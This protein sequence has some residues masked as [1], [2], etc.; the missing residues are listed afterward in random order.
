MALSLFQRIFQQML[1][2]FTANMGRGPVSPFEWNEIQSAAV[3]HINKTKGVPE[4]STKD[5]FSGWKPEI[6]EQEVKK[7][8]IIDF[9]KKGITSLLKSGEVKVGKAPKTQK[10]TLDAKKGVLDKQIS[11]EMRIKE[12]QRENKE[13]IERFRKKMEEPNPDDPGHYEDGMAYGGIAPLVGEPTYAANFYDDRIPMAGGGALF[14]FIERLFIKASNDIRQGK[15][16]W[17]GLDQNGSE[18]KATRQSYQES[19]GISKNRK[20][21]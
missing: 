8:E 7:A 13:A 5:P 11:K 6:V 12:I 18:N 15:G 1:K 9:P 3:R 17:K 20:T 19:Y 2:R 10:S 21:P 4:K 14:K 16:K